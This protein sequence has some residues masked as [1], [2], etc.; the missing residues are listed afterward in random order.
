MVDQATWPEEPLTPE[1]VEAHAWHLPPVV[2]TLGREAL[3]TPGAADDSHLAAGP[4]KA[5]APLR[6]GALPASPTN[7]NLTALATMLVGAGLYQH[8]HEDSATLD[9]DDLLALG[10]SV[11]PFELLAQQELDAEYFAGAKSGKAEPDVQV[12]SLEDGPSSEESAQT[13]DQDTDG[14]VVVASHDAKEG[15]IWSASSARSVAAT[16]APE[17]TGPSTEKVFSKAPAGGKPGPAEPVSGDAGDAIAQLPESEPESPGGFDFAPVA[18]GDF[19]TTD[20][21]TAVTV[22]VLANDSDADGDAISVVAVTQ[23]ANGAVIINDDNTV[24][25]TP[26]ADFN[27]TDSFGYTVADGDG[28]TDSATT[29]VT[30]AAVNDAPITNAA[31]ATGAE[32]DT[33]IPVVLSGSDIDGT[34]TH[35]AITT[36]SISATLYT[37]AALTDAVA[38]DT[39]YAATAETQT[40][41]AAPDADFDGVV[42]FDYVAKDDAGAADTAP[43]TAT[44]TLTSVND[45]PDGEADIAAT[46]TNEAVTIQVLDND[47]DPDGGT[48][49][50]DS[51][52]QGANGSVVINADNTVTFSPD[53]GFEGTETFTYTVADDDG[54]STTATVSVAVGDPI[55]GTAGDDTLNDTPEDHILDG[56]DGNDRLSGGGGNDTLIGGAGDDSLD[57]GKDD[58][59]LDGGAGSDTLNGGKGGDTLNGGKGNDTLSGGAGDDALEGGKGDDWLD[60][61]AGVDILEGGNGNDVLVWDSADAHIDGDGGTDTLR[62]DGGAADLTAFAGTIKAIEH[63]DLETD[64]GA[65]TLTLSAADVVAISGSGSLAVLGDAS[66]RVEAGSGW[67][68]GGVDGAGLRTYYQGGATLFIDPDVNVNTDILA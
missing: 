6:N 53:A 58:D 15:A 36:L 37:N 25:Y 43:S 11:G 61:G 2:T 54:D 40:L 33:A 32:D 8:L 31:A 48:L 17:D 34:V 30:V 66:D 59:W 35:F 27:G 65:N 24:T 67:T 39:D 1:V 18:V 38:T 42:D 63:I 22:A 57:G 52:T 28:A 44:I 55:E 68:D 56:K 9:F 14:G 19:T 16:D 21:D 4:E 3:M 50:I 62:V 7:L 60:G 49:A 12:A 29:V 51:V 5:D 23:G 45:A 47:S 64:I 46:H 13:A 26:D 20:E 10:V 41:Y